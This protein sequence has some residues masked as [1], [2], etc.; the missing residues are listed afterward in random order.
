MRKYLFWVLLN[1]ANKASYTAYNLGTESCKRIRTLD[2]IYTHSCYRVVSPFLNTGFILSASTI[3]YYRHISPLSFS[4]SW[5]LKITVLV[6]GSTNQLKHQKHPLES[7]LLPHLPDSF[8]LFLY[9]S[10]WFIFDWSLKPQSTK[11]WRHWWDMILIGMRVMRKSNLFCNRY[12]EQLVTESCLTTA[13]APPPVV[14]PNL[15]LF[16]AN[17]PDLCYDSCYI[18][19]ESTTPWAI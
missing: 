3:V 4:L 13:N 5:D 15:E 10:K 12:N 2:H 14:T 8:A 1:D 19:Q 7:L 16:H 6:I 17:T 18:K 11:H 9:Y